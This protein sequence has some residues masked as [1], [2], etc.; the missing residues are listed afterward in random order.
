[1][2]QYHR[3]H[4]PTLSFDV[5]LADRVPVRLY[6]A[7]LFN[8]VGVAHP[9]QKVLKAPFYCLYNCFVRVYP[10]HLAVSVP[11]PQVRTGLAG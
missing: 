4:P 3:I 2:V 8:R 11:E 1:M 5:Q 10:N 9:V 7:D 6:E